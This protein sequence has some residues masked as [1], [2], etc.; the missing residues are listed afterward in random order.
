MRGGLKMVGKGYSIEDGRAMVKTM[1]ETML[2]MAGERFRSGHGGQD[3]N[4]AIYAV[5]TEIA[6]EFR[7]RWDEMLEKDLCKCPPAVTVRLLE[8]IP[9]QKSD[10]RIRAICT[11]CGKLR[12]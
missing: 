8:P 6:L 3:M 4:T 5:K 10:Y 7:K 12:P 2:W 11:A 1:V 9:H